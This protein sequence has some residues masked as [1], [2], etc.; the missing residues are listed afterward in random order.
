MYFYAQ[1]TATCCNTDSDNGVMGAALPSKLCAMHFYSQYS[2]TRCNTLQRTEI[3]CNSLQ[4]T[5]PRI[6]ALEILRNVVLYAAHHNE[7]QQIEK[8]QNIAIQCT[9]LQFTTML[10]G[11]CLHSCTSR[12]KIMIHTATHCNTLQHTATHCNTLQRT[13]THCNTLQTLPPR[14]RWVTC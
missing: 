12:H 10:C 8:E 5:A 9:T 1:H 4:H 11:T 7:L 13:A 14:W 6:F 2:A 3:H